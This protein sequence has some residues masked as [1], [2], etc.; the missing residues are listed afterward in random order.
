[1]RIAVTGIGLQAFRPGVAGRPLEEIVFETVR[2]ALQDAGIDHDALDSVF[3]GSSDLVDGR[4]ISCMTTAGA[5]GAYDKEMTNFSSSAEHAFIAACMKIAS[6]LAETCLVVSWGMASA[7]S[8]EL[9]DWVNLDY[10]HLRPLGLNRMTEAAQRASRYMTERSFAETTLANIVCAN[11]IHGSRNVHAQ[12]RELT[13]LERVLSSPFLSY[14]LRE[15]FVATESDGACAL[16]LQG[17]STIRPDA[18]AA[19]VAGFGWATDA[20]W[21]APRALSPAAISAATSAYRMADIADPPQDIQVVE[22]SA[23]SVCDE[24]ASYEELGLCRPGD[25]PAFNASKPDG[26]VINPSG[27]LLCSNIPVAAN[28]VRIAEVACQVRGGAQE[29]QVP[30]TQAALA[31]CASGLFKESSSVIVLRNSL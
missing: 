18:P 3:M 17:M 15:D 13:S 24:L 6:G 10:M 7:I 1:M 2:I 12:V 28:L 22:L 5:A 4:V 21:W 27:G 11:R 25:G 20:Y 14:P 19:W 26:I 8:N 23:F 30:G 16:V 31:F 9:I 29:R